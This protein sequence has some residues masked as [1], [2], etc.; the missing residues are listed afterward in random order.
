MGGTEALVTMLQEGYLK[1][2]VSFEG[3]CY[4]QG[5]D[6]DCRMIKLH[7][8]GLGDANTKVFSLHFSSLMILLCVLFNPNY[9]LFVLPGVHHS[10]VGVFSGV[11]QS[12][13]RV[14]IHQRTAGRRD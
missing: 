4:L 1:C 13:L 5:L 10:T 14:E 11:E 7:L 9:N 3:P 12:G 8:A 2:S 6:S